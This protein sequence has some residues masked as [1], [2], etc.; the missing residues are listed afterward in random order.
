[1]NVPVPA[2]QIRVKTQV[3]LDGHP[4]DLRLSQPVQPYS[5]QALIVYATGDGGWLGLGTDIFEWL[6]TWNY[7]VVGYSSRNYI[8]HLGYSSA[9]ETT[10][11]RRLA[12]DY[13]SMIA[14]AEDKLGLPASTQVILVGLSRGAG[15]SVVVAGSGVLD[16]RLAGLLAIALTKEEEHVVR[17]RTRPAAGGA[18][19]PK[20]ESV[21]IETYRYL[22]RS[23]P[24]PVM[25]LQ[26]THDGY[27]PADEA[28]ILFGPDTELRRLRAVES[29]NHGFRNGCQ[30]LYQDAKD[31]IE[32]IINFRR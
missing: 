22:N 13:E 29:A 7:P 2:G 6:A 27:L 20:R 16:H 30:T 10:T 32:W 1:M 15:L 4:F 28:R 26:S 12:R 19:A 25:V 21:M 8:H 31:A 18:V 17:L 11:P 23:V 24:F 14:F 3:T 5:H 9:D